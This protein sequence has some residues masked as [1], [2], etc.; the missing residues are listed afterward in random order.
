MR[1]K[2]I[3]VLAAAF[4][5]LG[6]ALPAAQA[7]TAITPACGATSFCG[8]QTLDSPD[9]ALAVATS[10]PATGTKVI[11]AVGAAD[12]R[13]DFLMVSP[14]NPVNNDKLFRYA[15]SGVASGYCMSEP[16]LDVKTLIVL[17]KCNGSVFQQWTPAQFDGSVNTWINNASGF[18]LSD[19]NSGPAGT[20][21][22]S[23]RAGLG[24]YAG[25]LWEFTG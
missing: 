18:A 4:A 5:A 22:V 1:Y 16:S 21:L 17:R 11:V 8:G 2:L 20:Q 14:A 12:P 7:A 25:E 9:L 19:P 6:L 3:A 10:V 24:T 15:P 13:Q 23:R